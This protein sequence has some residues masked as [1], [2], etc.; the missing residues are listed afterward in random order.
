MCYPKVTSRL[1][2]PAG[3]VNPQPSGGQPC[4][5]CAADPNP[6]T[7]RPTRSRPQ[8]EIEPLALVRTSQRD[9]VGK[10]RTSDK[11]SRH[12]QLDSPHLPTPT[13]SLCQS[14]MPPKRTA[15]SRCLRTSSSPGTQAEAKSPA[16]SIET[17]VC[18]GSTQPRLNQLQ[19][20]RPRPL[21]TKGDSHPLDVQRSGSAASCK[22]APRVG[23][24]TQAPPSAPPLQRKQC[25][26]QRPR[27]RCP[28]GLVLRRRVPIRSGFCGQTRCRRNRSLF[29]HPSSRSFWRTATATRSAAWLRVASSR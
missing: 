11:R 9:S 25:H 7:I 22:P 12:P 13:L 26:R 18:Q 10:Q 20:R 6:R 21:P 2:S 28:Y 3:L 24:R 4:R 27:C 23:T 8:S 19:A 15:R 1:P 14:R 16:V 17:P 5:A 29:L